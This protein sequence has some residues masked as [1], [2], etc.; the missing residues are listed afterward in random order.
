M[1]APLI[2]VNERA[3]R[4]IGGMVELTEDVLDIGRRI[5]EGDESGWRGDPSMK[6]CWNPM[7]QKYEVVGIDATG[8]EY[9][10]ASHDTCDHTLLVKLVAGDPRKHNVV[11]E[12][13][14]ANRKLREGQEAADREKAR[15]IADKLQ[16][17][18]RKDLG[19]HLGGTKRMHSMHNRKGR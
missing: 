16:W 3:P 18:I 17:A 15:E 9:L 11:Y 7:T 14:E 12:V 10:A 2:F 6:L 8:S 19:Q 13:I 1:G 4:I 5:R